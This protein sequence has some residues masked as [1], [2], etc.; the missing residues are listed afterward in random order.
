MRITGASV[1]DHR[2]GFVERDIYTDGPRITHFS[3][4]GD[5]YDARGMY[6]I[7]GLTDLH[8]HG[9]VGEDFSDATADGLRRIAEYELHRGVTQ[10][11]PAGM[12]LSEEQIRAICRNAARHARAQ[13]S[14]AEGAG[15]DL[16]GLN[17]EGPF[18]CFA[19]KGAQNAAFLRKPDPALLAGFQ[20]AAEGLV[21]L[22]TLA[23]EEGNA[24]AFIHKA[25]ELGV[26]VSLGHTNANYEQACAAYA[27]G[28]RQATHLFNAMPPFSHREPGVVGAAF[29][30]PDVSVELISDGIH[31]HPNVLRAVFKLFGPERVILISDSLR[32]TGMPDGVYPFG[33]QMIEVH[34]S[35]AHMLGEAGT[36]AG[37]VSDLMA[38]LRKAVSFGIPLESAVRAASYNPAKALGIDSNY[39]SLDAGKMANMAVLNADLELQTVIFHGKRLDI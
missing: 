28:A 34:G 18:L 8:F 12:T 6:L 9:C 5:V 36:L 33:G 29:E 24:Q 4:D 38:C 27:A 30:Y 21:K 19:K 20:E 32:A 31:I 10:I 13:M 16:V 3:G 17:L 25:K 26:R 23:P 39:G 11:C 2:E 15:A 1:Y 7:P 37:S 22:V 14:G 35:R